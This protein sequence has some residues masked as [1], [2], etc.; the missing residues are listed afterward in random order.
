MADVPDPE[1]D[2]C[3]RQLIVTMHNIQLNLDRA[4]RK[5]AML[6]IVMD[7]HS[8]PAYQLMI[9]VNP[10]SSEDLKLG[11]NNIGFLIELGNSSV[12]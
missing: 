12:P 4:A 5:L 6:Q 9:Q 2:L 3:P 11:Y 7:F 8:Y 1:L 10:F